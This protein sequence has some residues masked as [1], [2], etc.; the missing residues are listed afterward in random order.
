MS[1]YIQRTRPECVHACT[2]DD[3]AHLLSQVPSTDW[4]GLDAIVLRQPRREEQTLAP[5]WGRLAYAADLTNSKGRILYSGP[6]IILEA[7][8]PAAPFKFGKSLSMDGTAE[9][10][11]LICDGHKLRPGDPSINTA[12]K[13]LSFVSASASGALASI[14]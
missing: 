11:R 6:A 1:F 14:V 12:R 9:L 3:I 10:K 4:E 5:V 8:I 7:F 13:R 2:V